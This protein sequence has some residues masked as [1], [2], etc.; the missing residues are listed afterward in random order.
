MS[1]ASRLRAASLVLIGL[2]LPVLAHSQG[3]ALTIED[4]YKVKTVGSAQLSGDG[5]WVASLSTL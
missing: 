2:A 4:Y 5:R 3:R 1:F